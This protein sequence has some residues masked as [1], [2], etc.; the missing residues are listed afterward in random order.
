MNIL[1]TGA[2]GFIGRQ[3]LADLIRNGHSVHVLSRTAGPLPEIPGPGS[4][5]VFH[6][7]ILDPCSIGRAV[8]G[9]EAVFHLAGY[10]RNWA[11]N[12]ETFLEVNLQG[13]KNVL[14]AAQDASVRRVVYTSSV[15]TFGPSTGS[16]IDETVDRTAPMLT[17]YELSKRAA[18][19]EA[20][21]FCRRGLDV[22]M[23]NPTRVFGPGLLNEGN[24]VTR[25]IKWYVEGKWHAVLGNGSAIGNY[26]FVQDVSLGHIQALE[27]GRAGER[28]ILGGEN[29][30]FD[31]LFALVARIAGK[32]HTLVH[33]P[34]PLALA[35]GYVEELRGRMHLGYPAITP[36]WVKTFLGDWTYSCRKAREDL[37]YRITPLETALRLTLDWLSGLQAGGDAHT[38]T[39]SHTATDQCSRSPIAEGV[40]T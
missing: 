32:R 17:G 8:T 26:A 9:C 15:M 22:V 11:R 4:V 36:P 12:L 33:I 3:L 34:G 23:V 20:V 21:E 35:I 39:R 2:T 37:G 29:I 10:A 18:E 6:G 16:A 1:I 27:R 19:E 31:E 24:S 5:E 28:Y 38:N 40:A 25:M 14:K 7:D 13:T 30:S